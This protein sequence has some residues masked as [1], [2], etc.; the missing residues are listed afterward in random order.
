V[1]RSI[2]VVAGYQTAMNVLVTGASG[3]VGTQLCS[4]LSAAG[5]TVIAMT[6]DPSEYTGAGSPVYGDIAEPASLDRA[7]GG[8]DAAYYLVHSLDQPD[9]SE[10]DRSGARAFG[11]AA[12]GAGVGQVI[13]LGGLGDEADDLSEHLDS[14]REVE[15]IL[16]ETA[17]TTALRAGIVIGDGGISWEILRQLVERLPVMITPRWVQTQT[18]PIAI[19]DATALLV[20]V[21]G[22]PDAI[23]ATF[24]AAGPDRLTYR[25]MLETVARITA[26]RRLIVPVPFL[27]PRLSSHWLRLITDVDLPTAR[28]LVDSLANE[29]VARDHRIDDLVGHQSMGFADA[30]RKA[31]QARAD[32][33]RLSTS[34]HAAS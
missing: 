8:C 1:A 4:A 21:L 9:F 29:V 18:Q 15:R 34:T 31:L 32:R 6:R 3:F 26:R 16:F 28:A 14:R 20:G 12:V 27:S 25:Q 2:K 7:L 19:D 13:Y 11:R 24:D 33:L 17:P 30:T 5:H 22:R 23:G 10:R